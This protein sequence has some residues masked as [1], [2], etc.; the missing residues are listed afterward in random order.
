M[1]GFFD[2]LRISHVHVTHL[3]RLGCSHMSRVGYDTFAYSIVQEHRTSSTNRRNKFLFFSDL[4]A[5]VDVK[6]N[7]TSPSAAG[8]TLPDL[9]STR[10]TPVPSTP[11]VSFFASSYRSNVTW[12]FVVLFSYP[13]HWIFAP[14]LFSFFLY[15]CK[16]T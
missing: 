2:S 1:P 13:F 4:F 15:D 11:C 14:I 12:Q 10:H 16:I 3:D 5:Q 6:G 9:K 8:G 7:G